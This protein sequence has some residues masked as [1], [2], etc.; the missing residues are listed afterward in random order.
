MFE[1][2]KKIKI[3]GGYFDE[4]TELELFKG[5]GALSIV[6]GRN[7]SG[8]STIARCL[9]QLSE[10]EEERIEREENVV[11]GKETSYTVNS[12]APIT[13]EHKSG[14]FVFDEDFLRNNVRVENDGLNAI[15]M[16]GEQVELDEKINAKN[17]ELSRKVKEFNQQEE[18]VKKYGNSGENISP[19]YYWDQIREGLREDGG[20]ADIDRDLKGNTLKSRITDDLVNMLMEIEE[21][22]ETYERLREQVVADMR[23]YLE[24]ENSQVIVWAAGELMLPK[25]LEDLTV[26]LESP[27]DSPQLTE[28]EQ[29]LLELLT[30]TSW[31]PQHF[32]QYH[33]R[34]MLE[35]GWTFCP[36]C[37]RE[38][39]EKDRASIAEVL[40]HL[41][42]KEADKFNARLNVVHEQFAAIDTEMP[43]FPGNLNRT[44]LQAATTVKEGLNKVLA[45]VREKIELRKRNIYKPL[46]TPFADKMDKEYANACTAWRAALKRVQKCVETFNE[47]VSKRNKLFERI[48]YKN[49]LLARKQLAS[50]LMGYKM[51]L[52]NEDKDK[53]KLQALK[54][55]KDELVAAIKELKMQKERTDIALEYINKE[56]QYVFYSNCKVKLSPSAGC[57]KLTVNGKE[58]KP[59]KISVGER[60]VLG[61][62]Y[63]FAMLF[64]GKRDEDKYTS[65]YLIVIDDPISSFDCGNRLGV[66]SLLRYQFSNIK[67]G[68]TN[69]RLLVMSHDLQSVFDLVKIRSDLQGGRGEKKFLE[70]ENKKIKEQLVRNEYQKLLTHVYEYASCDRPEDLDAT[71][72]MGIGNIMRRMLEAFS[73]FCYNKPFETMMRTEGVISN[74]PEDKR[75]YYENFMCRLT[76]NGESHEEE[77]AYT[78]SNFTPFFTKEEKLQTAK[79]V[80]LFLLYVNEPH[81]KAYLKPEVVA[82]IESWKYEENNWISTEPTVTVRSENT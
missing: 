73:S 70:L 28:R 47:T 17:E 36:L 26:L 63:F 13:D 76:L 75:V 44:E 82:K 20:W 60:N 55:Q 35:E 67:R 8:K 80:L 31:E 53:R 50:A 54:E 11:L 43:E 62:C 4:E 72:E 37:L 52:A 58:V 27:L 29:R 15:V 21:P 48:R 5:D 24:S 49:N 81:I 64:S 41:L 30:I 16:L 19:R 25:N 45:A 61:L 32:E 33:T 12:E 68:N 71:A 18:Q 42:N 57:Y 22:A 3:K 9:K 40:T 51:A 77:R 59:K 14:V 23:L 38:I 78:L 79:S 65:E 2:F 7:G 66:M 34:H 46:Q 1:N 6:Y 10:S 56:L 39:T 69:S 74:I